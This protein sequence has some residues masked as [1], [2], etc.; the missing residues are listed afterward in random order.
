MEDLIVVGLEGRWRFREALGDTWEWWLRSKPPAGPDDEPDDDAVADAPPGPV[1]GAGALNNAAA[2]AGPAAWVRSAWL[3]GQVPGS[4]IGDLTRCGELAEPRFE[5]SSRAAEW[6][7]SRSWVYRRRVAL[8]ASARS[9]LAGGARAQLVFR[10]VDPAARVFVDGAEQGRLTGPYATQTIDVSEALARVAESFD[11]AVVLEPN[12]P[13]EPQVGRTDRVVR[14]APRLNNGWDFCPP[15]PHQGIWQGVSLEVGPVLLSRPV[16]VTRLV[17]AARPSRSAGRA[18]AGRVEFEATRLGGRGDP[19]LTLRLEQGSRRIAQAPLRA[20][21]SR[22]FGRVEADRVSFWQPWGL[23]DQAMATVK[24][25]NAR[26]HELLAARTGFR[27]VEWRANPRAPADALAYTLVVNGRVIDPVGWNWTPADAQYGC[28]T[29]ERLE[30][31]LRLA[32]DSGAR[33]LRVWGGGLVETEAFYDL[34]DSLGLLVWQEFSQSSSGTQSAP[35]QDPAFVDALGRQARGLVGERS[36]HPSLVLWDGGN[37]LQDQAGPLSTA[38][39]PALRALAEAVAAPAGGVGWLPTSPSGPTFAFGPPGGE[40]DHR[41]D[42]HGPWEHQGLDDHTRLYNGAAALAHTEFGV[43]GMAARRQLEAIIAPG[44]RWP[45]TRENPCYRHLGEW[46]NNAEAVDAAFGGQILGGS[47]R[48]RLDAL[49]PDELI[50]RALDRCRRAS[51]L[52]QATGLAYAVEADRRRWPRCSLV[53]P[54]QLNESFP[55][56]WCT[57]VVDHCGDPKPA[58]WA[59][60]R[61]FAPTRATIEVDTQVWAGRT[62]VEAVAWAWDFERRPRP[63]GST[64]TLRLIGLDGRE[65]ARSQD[66][67][68]DWD[69]RPRPAARLS[70]PLAK[71]ERRGEA[72]A[73]WEAQWR[74][75]KGRLVDR[76]RQLAGLAAHWGALV[77][78]PRCQVAPSLVRAAVSPDG[79]ALTVANAGAVALIGPH[80]TD[81]RPFGASGFVRLTQDPR[82]LLPGERTRVT[83]S[84]P[85]AGGHRLQLDWVNNPSGPVTVRLDTINTT[86]QK[87]RR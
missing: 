84:A 45:P 42:V 37:E 11:L 38:R 15:F 71:L 31:L 1:P 2:A 77:A 73:L 69:G 53:L 67:L 65:L 85:A 20:R 75:A 10:G 72:M 64:M 21:G 35:S 39:S 9:A 68:E 27:S 30:H 58:F 23:G 47:D 5:R 50:D 74:D 49:S 28:V 66:R 6:T 57:A 7:A 79:R 43:E 16:I 24:V 40:P 59:V 86:A 81:A 13:G 52:L 26:G 62:E 18:G 80:V 14:H 56:A 36:R 61:A 12:P 8:T 44:H 19:G 17:G 60:A 41:H 48:G 70:A 54:W 87:G 63:A 83:L 22:V 33:L 34:A 82:P 4:V 25:V 3:P 78:E 55:N 46:W 29:P 76:E 32:R 51:Q